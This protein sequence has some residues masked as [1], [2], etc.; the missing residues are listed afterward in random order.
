MP[1]MHALPNQMRKIYFGHHVLGL[2]AIISGITTL[3]WRDLNAW[4]DVIALEHVPH[5]QIFLF[6]AGAIQLVG[7]ILIQWRHTRRIGAFLLGVI[8]LTFTLLWVPEI[9]AS[10][11]V[12]GVWGALFYPFSLLSGALIVYGMMSQD[13]SIHR[14]VRIGYVC[15]GICQVPFA[16]EQLAYFPNTVVLV[17][18]WIPPGQVFWAIAT[19]IAFGLAAVALLS[20]RSALLAARLLT[21]MLIAFGVLIWVPTVISN[22][23]KLFNWTE[24]NENLA[25]AGVAWIVADYLVQKR[26]AVSPSA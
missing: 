4:K 13:E 3:T 16:I 14:L 24:H 9:V 1:T 7:G 26:S 20:G 5:P 8:Y 15:F 10:P 25:I 21:I 19:T 23:H 11:L 17:P 22:P 12:V 18:K 2:A 6:I